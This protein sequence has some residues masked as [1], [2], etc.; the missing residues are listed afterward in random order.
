VKDV[1]RQWVGWRET[2]KLLDCNFTQREIMK[3]PKEIC[4]GLTFTV[5]F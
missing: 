2:R 1:A 4:V 3:C 5:T